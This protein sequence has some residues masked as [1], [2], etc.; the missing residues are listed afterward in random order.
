MDSQDCEGLVPPVPR[1]SD[2]TKLADGSD[3]LF[4]LCLV[5]AGDVGYF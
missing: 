4:S 1:G 3:S 5:F 2:Q